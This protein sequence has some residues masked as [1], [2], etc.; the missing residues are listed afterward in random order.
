MKNATL[1][2]LRDLIITWANDKGILSKSNPNRQTLKLLEEIG[3]LGKAINENNLAQIMDGV[4]DTYVVVTILSKM[5]GKEI[6]DV[7]INTK[8]LVDS[9]TTSDLLMELVNQVYIK[10]YSFA[11]VLLNALVVKL[12]T[13]GEVTNQLSIEDT[14][15]TLADCVMLAYQQIS[16]RTGKMVNGV[17]VKDK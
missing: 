4:G 9:F 7:I 5:Q 11:L 14:D 2:Q 15:Y 16:K 13:T 3:E 10:D 12:Q 6:Q 8:G 17:F 1:P